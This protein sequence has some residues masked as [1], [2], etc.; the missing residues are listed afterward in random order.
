M[1]DDFPFSF[2]PTR[3]E[4]EKEQREW[5]EMDRK[6]QEKW[7]QEQAQAAADGAPGNDEAESSSIW[8]SSM[9]AADPRRQPPSIALFGIG[10]HLAE[11]GED[12]KAS[13]ETEPLVQT[14]NRQFGNLRAAIGDPA[15]ALVEPVVQRFCSELDSVAEARP[16]LGPK[17]ADL[18]RQLTELAAHLSAEEDPDDDLPF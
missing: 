7:E 6:F 10:S 16:D 13:P 8:Q 15:P 9:S 17:C 11:L 3:D 5:A 2:H 1:D 12:L 4:W 18:E 14:L